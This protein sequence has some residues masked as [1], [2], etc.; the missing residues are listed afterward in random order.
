M[1]MM[2]YCSVIGNY[3]ATMVFEINQWNLIIVSSQHDLSEHSRVV[4]LGKHGIGYKEKALPLLTI[5]SDHL[6]QGRHTM[7]VWDQ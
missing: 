6:H 4:N 7:P 2:R 3:V 5:K 1:P